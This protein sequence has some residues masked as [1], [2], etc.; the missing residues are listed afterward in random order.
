MGKKYTYTLS[1]D[2]K[3]LTKADLQERFELYNQLYFDGKLG[4][5]NFFWL[6]ANPGD[7]GKYN[8]KHTKQGDVS[9]IGVARSTDWTEETLRELLVHEMIHMYVTTVEGV[10]HDGVLGHG[11]HFRKHMKRLK[12]EHDLIITLHG[13]NFPLKDKKFAPKWWEKLILWIIDR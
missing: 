2:G 6:I 7:Y 5:C 1:V 9:M 13:E 4:K 8:L 11:R 3:G 10:K 12:Q